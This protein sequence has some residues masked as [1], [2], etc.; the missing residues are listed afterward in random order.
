MIV[1]FAMPPPS[2]MVWR[3]YR[4]P[5]RS[6]SLRSVTMSRA[7]DAPSGWPSAIAPPF[8]LTLLMSGWCSFSHASTTGANASL[9]STRSMSSSF[10]PARSST[11]VVAGMGPVSMVTGSTPAS[12]NAWKGAIGDRRRVA[13][14]DDA[15]GLERGL[16]LGQRLE[17]GV[18]ADA[19]VGPELLLPAVD[20][21]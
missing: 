18:G 1:A 21:D 14:G 5:V 12:A 20:L 6:S 2:H 15:V 3:P 9:I 16:E 13:G 11:L 8:T 4:P 10:M 17:A 19:L 7:P